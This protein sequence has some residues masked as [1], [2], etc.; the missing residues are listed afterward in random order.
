M[1]GETRRRPGTVMGLVVAAVIHGAGATAQTVTPAAPPASAT[2]K[3]YDG[4]C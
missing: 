2:H 3:H 1:I 4:L